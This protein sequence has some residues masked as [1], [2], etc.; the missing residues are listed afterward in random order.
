MKFYVESTNWGDK[1]EGLVEHYPWL[2]DF[3]YENK[4]ITID[5]LEVLMDLVNKTGPRNGICVFPDHM[6]YD[7]KNRKWVS[8]GVPHIEIYD[9]YR[10]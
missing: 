2:K 4:H 6:V 8:T 10:E 3:G 5:S 1:E 7:P 9:G